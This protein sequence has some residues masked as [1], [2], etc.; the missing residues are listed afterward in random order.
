LRIAAFVPLADF[1]LQVSAQT[2]QHAFSSAKLKA[3]HCQRR[4]NPNNPNRG[5]FRA[6]EP[7]CYPSTGGDQFDFRFDRPPRFTDKS[8]T[9][10]L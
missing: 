5:C 1:V 7:D 2:K 8:P 4:Y 9:K 6:E 3:Q 10:L